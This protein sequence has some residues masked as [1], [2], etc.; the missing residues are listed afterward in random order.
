[1]AIRRARNP[2]GKDKKGKRGPWPRF[3]CVLGVALMRRRRKTLWA[4]LMGIA[5]GA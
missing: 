5:K 1:M 3:F 2:G 4:P